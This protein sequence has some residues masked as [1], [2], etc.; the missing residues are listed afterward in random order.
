MELSPVGASTTAFDASIA[1]IL[2][3]IEINKKK[4]VALRIK[5]AALQYKHAALQ[6][7]YAALQSKHV[8]FRTKYAALQ[9]KHAALRTKYAALLKSRSH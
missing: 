1:D 6:T 4:N 5:Y 8:A 2:R 9:S 3:A 7:N